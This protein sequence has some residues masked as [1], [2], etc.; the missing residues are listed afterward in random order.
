MYSQKYKRK[1]ISTSKITKFSSREEPSPYTPGPRTLALE[2]SAID[3]KKAEKDF[4]RDNV[5]IFMKCEENIL[6][7]HEKYML[8]FNL[9]KYYIILLKKFRAG[10]I[11][12]KYQEDHYPG[13]QWD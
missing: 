9:Q 12:K 5:Q 8:A 6:K 3:R 7:M 11:S 4:L 13:L 2:K 10:L 1:D